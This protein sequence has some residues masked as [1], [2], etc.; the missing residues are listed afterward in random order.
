[1]SLLFSEIHEQPVII[2]RLLASETERVKAIVGQVRGKFDYVLIAARGS[3]DNAARYA[4]YLFGVQNQIQVALATPSVFTL[5]QR[6]PR[7]AGALVVGISQSGQSPDIVAVIAEAHQQG[8]PTIAITNKVE[9]PLAQAAAHVVNLQAG[10]EGAVAATKTYT[11]SLAALALLSTLLTSNAAHLS[12]LNAA[13][14]LM[15]QTLA[16][17][18][19]ALTRAERYRFLDRCV[20]IGR[21]YNYATAFEIA[22]KVKEL[23]RVVAEPYSSADFRH[24]PIALARGDVPVLAIAPSGLAEEDMRTLV[25]DLAKLGTEVIAVSADP[26]IL[27]SARVAWP[28]PTGVP[29]WLSPLVAVLPGQLFGMALAE[30]K[31]YDPDKPVGLTKVTETL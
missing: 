11:A 30:A 2:R 5:Y 31:G 17:S 18:S 27:D 10:D 8:R 29:E 22:L 13:P 25:T 7:L 21:G 20:V 28:L 26:A 6:P 12:Q 4:Q 1:L 16:L 14:A 23:T 3:S 15:E 24:G 19:P 9:S